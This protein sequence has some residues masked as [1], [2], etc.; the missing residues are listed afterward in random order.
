MAHR[1][2]RHGA[3]LA[4]MALAAG[5]GEQSLVSP[6]ATSRAA[7][8]ARNADATSGT[9]P[10]YLHS[11]AIKY[12]D[13]GAHPATGRSGS[14]SIMS[15]ALLG[16]DGST[17]V[18]ATTGTLDQGAAPGT[19]SKVQ[20][21]LN[22]VGTLSTANYNGLNAGGY[23][24][25]SYT[26]LQ[27]SDKVQVQANVRGIDGSRNDVVTVSNDVRLRPDLAA[28]NLTAPAKAKVNTVVDISA[29]V[30]ELNH[31]VGARATCVLTVDG[32]TVDH[33]DGIWVDAGDA[34]TCAF[35]NTFTTLGNHTIAVSATNVVPGDWDTANNTVTGTIEIVN[36]EVRLQ[37]NMYFDAR[38]GTYA[39]TYNDDWYY[40]ESE[41]YDYH[42]RNA[43]IYATTTD[44][45]PIN[46]N[47]TATAVLTSDNVV[48]ANAAIALPNYG[49]TCRSGYD[50]VTN[51]SVNL[52][53]YPSGAQLNAQTYA[54]RT[55]YYGQYYY[56][57]EV[58]S[59]AD[60][61]GVA[62]Y[63]V[64]STI[65]YDVKVTDAAGTQWRAQGQVAPYHQH[66]QYDNGAYCSAYYYYYC[67]NAN[68]D[69]WTGSN[70]G[71]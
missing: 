61:Y 23:W 66:V 10:S 34:V 45:T 19:I 64:G 24:T 69:S 26:G 12:A 42:Y 63:A 46:G 16:K 33:A 39:Y 43:S 47:A 50:P 29:Q 55:T 60:N 20:A 14:A 9:R 7:S 18:E 70:S 54:S 32:T 67:E 35:Q 48:V 44:A 8:S 57:G 27:R 1:F 52:C 65:G 25:Q 22:H 40:N 13:N 6:A 3:W 28:S 36:P 31:D 38:E 11:N 4:A 37:W 30:S 5:C 59:Y 68:Y 21:K 58:Y 56:Y 49:G 15:R 53:T 41:S 71:N 62:P 17:V 2:T 51:T